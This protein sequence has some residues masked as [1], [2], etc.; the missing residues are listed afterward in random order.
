MDQVSLD[1]CVQWMNIITQQVAT[2]YQGITRLVAQHRE[3]RMEREFK[4]ALVR[5]PSN[6][7]WQKRALRRLQNL[8]EKWTKKRTEKEKERLHYCMIKGRKIKK[9]I[10]Q[11][12]HPQQCMHVHL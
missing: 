4:R 7:E 3:T 1:E 11:A 5:V 12:L 8:N 10:D 6:T 2:A 9:A